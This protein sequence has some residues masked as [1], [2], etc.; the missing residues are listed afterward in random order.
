MS[1][2]TLKYCETLTLKMWK[3]TNDFPFHLKHKD[4]FR[5]KYLR[6]CFLIFILEPYRGRPSKH[7]L[8]YE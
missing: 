4:N 1:E 8:I 2:P 6:I 5:I 7:Y 3:S